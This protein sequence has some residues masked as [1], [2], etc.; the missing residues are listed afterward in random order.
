VNPLEGRRRISGPREKTEEPGQLTE[1]ACQRSYVSSQ[2][3]PATG[4][5]FAAQRRQHNS[6]LAATTIAFTLVPAQ[7]AV[8]LARAGLSITHCVHATDPF[9]RETVSACR[10][11]AAPA[12]SAGGT[13]GATV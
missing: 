13:R 1:L 10:K 3:G 4:H 11:K 9:R 8:A 12:Y 5:G 2:R 6:R 7:D